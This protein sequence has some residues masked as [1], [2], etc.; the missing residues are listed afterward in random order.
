MRTNYTNRPL[1]DVL[2]D[3]STYSGWA[4]SSENIQM[5]GIFF[6]EAVHQYTAQAA[7]YMK[8]AN[9]A[10]RAASGLAGDKTVR[11][12]LISASPP[13]LNTDKSNRSFTILESCQIQDSISTQPTSRSSLSNLTM[14]TDHSRTSFT[15]YRETD[16][17]T[18]L[19]CIRSRQRPISKSSSTASADMQ[20]ISTSRHLTR[21]TM[22]NSGPVGNRLP[23][24]F[25]HEI[26]EREQRDGPCAFNFP[27]GIY[28]CF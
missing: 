20:S 22:R 4:N 7:E 24:P 18:A 17:S 21:T 14:N 10:V 12:I 1:A 3:I 2:Q 15:R 16:P 5:H 27:L 13:P 6:D 25:Q 26:L 11:I 9:D 19:W 28:N 8:E 23:R